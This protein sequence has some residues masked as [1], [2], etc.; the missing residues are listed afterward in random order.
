MAGWNTYRLSR[1]LSDGEAALVKALAGPRYSPWRQEVSAPEN[2]G[3]LVE[4]A[5]GFLGVRFSV[6]V[7]QNRAAVAQNRAT[8]AL[9]GELRDWVPSFMT[10]YQR[11]FVLSCGRMDGVY[12]VAPAGSGKTLADIGYGLLEPGTIIFATPARVRR[13]VRRQIA[14]YTTA[15]CVLVEEILTAPPP[16]A[17]FVIVGWESLRENVEHLLALRPTTLVLDEIHTVKSGKRRE[18]VV[19]YDAASQSSVVDPKT[20][21]EKLRFRELKNRAM[22]AERLSRACRRRCA[23]TATPIPD[24]MRDLWGQLDLVVPEGFGKGPWH[25][26]RRYCGAYK[27]AFGYVTTG[28]AAPDYVAELVRRMD[29]FTYRVP[30]EVSHKDLP[31]ARRQ[32][33]MVRREELHT[34]RDVVRELKEH[35]F[36]KGNDQ[37]ALLA[38]AAAMKRPR[39]VEEALAGAVTYG[40]RM[41]AGGGKVTVFTGLRSECERI[42]AAVRKKAPAL[43]LFVGHGGHTQ[44][45][46]EVVQESYMAHPG[47]CLL[48]ATGESFGTGLDL[49][50]TDLAIHAMLPWTPGQV[51]QREQR[52]H[53][54]GQK[55]PVLNLYLIAEGTYDEHVAATLLEK[56]PA[57]VTVAGSKVMSEFEADMKGD[58][59]EIVE[60][61]VRKM[62]AVAEEG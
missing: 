22:A 12:C 13:Q 16:P 51:E 3:W 59:E 55:R 29:Y 44:E 31:P 48:V 53:R 19:D 21:G 7:A 35:P 54:L 9:P 25:F 33:V 50:D 40:G 23:S 2:A 47:P 60:G 38:L 57:V 15:D 17:R 26:Y 58:E 5:L 27:S 18:A 36:R 61:M 10:S 32:I 56:L 6:T 52:F 28:K 37:W 45:E 14:E 11:D 30:Q 39:V 20:G 42:A 8:A 1:R 24:R 43:D 34:G 62:M 46:R 41:G 49:H 4:S